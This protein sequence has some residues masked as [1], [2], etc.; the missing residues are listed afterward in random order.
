MTVKWKERWVR[1]W[2]T[3]HLVWALLWANH[4]S[5]LNTHFYN[6]EMIISRFL[7]TLTTNDFKGH[8]SYSDSM[9]LCK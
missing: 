8:K 1:N 6:Y 5:C 9:R 2:G 4:L 7:P 3:W